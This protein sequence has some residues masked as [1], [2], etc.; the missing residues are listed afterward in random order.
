MQTDV[1]RSSESSKDNEAC[2][3]EPYPGSVEPK[4]ALSPAHKNLLLKSEC[5]PVF[6][7]GDAPVALKSHLFP[8]RGLIST[9]QFALRSRT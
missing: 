9:D 6:S 1:V 8:R 7:I 2:S 4:T 5:D 3:L